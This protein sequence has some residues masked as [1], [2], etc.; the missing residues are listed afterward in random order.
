M[1][2][3]LTLSVVALL[4]GAASAV[5]QGPLP[6]DPALAAGVQAALGEAPGWAFA[7]TR[8]AVLPFVGVSL[9]AAC[10]LGWWVAGMRG[11]WAVP[12]AYGLALATDKTLRAVLFVP[13]PDPAL[14]AVAAPSA[15][16]GLPST[17]GLVY[18][19]IFGVAL[20]AGASGLRAALPARAVAAAAI[21]A[22]TAARVVLGGHWPS[23][24]VAS[25]ALG[26]LL[27]LA[28]LALA[29]RIAQR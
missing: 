25:L 1:R 9:V 5:L 3:S 20:M 6:G 10:L 23:Q 7:I 26:G 29:A 17:F 11:V 28:A 27:A 24:M 14:V 12:L 4:V 15:S 8:S 13:R 19:A 18:G 22:G 21:I 2:M 16:S